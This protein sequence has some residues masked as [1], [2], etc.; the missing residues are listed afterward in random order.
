MRHL[1]LE[2]V[3]GYGVVNL[4]QLNAGV[5]NQIATGTHYEVS[6]QADALVQ[7]W[8]KGEGFESRATDKPAYEPLAAT[9]ALALR[10]GY[11]IV[12][13]NRFKKLDRPP[14]NA[15]GAVPLSKW[16]GMTA[17]NGGGYEYALQG[18]GTIH[19]QPML[20][21]TGKPLVAPA[22]GPEFVAFVRELVALRDAI[23]PS[24]EFLLGGR[25]F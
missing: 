17:K 6:Q 10:L 16:P 3:D 11:E 20:P 5:A 22:G 7:Q 19:A 13:D 25:L 8:V 23:G 24:A 9:V 21:L 4:V 12:Y 2:S 14:L 18:N 15:T 1:L